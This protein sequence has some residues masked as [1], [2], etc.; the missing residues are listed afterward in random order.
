MVV[1]LCILLASPNLCLTFQPPR[2]E[3]DLAACEAAVHVLMCT[4][5]VKSVVYH[6]SFCCS[7]RLT[8]RALTCGMC[9]RMWFFQW[10]LDSILMCVFNSLKVSGSACVSLLIVKGK[11]LLRQT[12]AWQ[13]LHHG[14]AA[15]HWKRV[16]VFVS[17]RIHDAPVSKHKQ[18]NAQY[19]V[20][21]LT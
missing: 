1:R 18:N 13:M 2:C 12:S 7:Y 21:Q 15:Q 17:T 11:A 6:M 9:W 19:G 10:F 8:R 5:L 14:R 16:L 4:H 20:A 3:R